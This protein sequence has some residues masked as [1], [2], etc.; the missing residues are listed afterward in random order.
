MNDP[1]YVK[2]YDP[3]SKLGDINMGEAY[4]Q[5]YEHIPNCV[6]VSL[7]M[8]AHGM[9]IDKCRHLNQEPWMYTLAIFKRE[10]RNQPKV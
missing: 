8:F 6:I 2:P 5:Y 1:N 7:M 4:Y 3:A 9:L 10:L